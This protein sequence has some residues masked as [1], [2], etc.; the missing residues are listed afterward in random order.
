[1]YINYVTM[2]LTAL[3]LKINYH[4]IITGYNYKKRMQNL[5]VV[6]SLLQYCKCVYFRDM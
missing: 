3:V 4:E 2:M 5:K 6:L 1:V